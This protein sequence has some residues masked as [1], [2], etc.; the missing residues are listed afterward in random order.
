MVEGR[1]P[2]LIAG[3]G[4]P[5]VAI[6]DDRVVDVGRL[7]VDHADHTCSVWR[8]GTGPRWT[9]HPSELLD[10]GPIGRLNLPS[11]GGNSSLNSAR[12]FALIRKH[13]PMGVPTPSGAQE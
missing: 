3:V 9:V 6:T 1:S 2:D 7:V 12:A 4:V 10:V 5:V 13:H 8:Q 11:T